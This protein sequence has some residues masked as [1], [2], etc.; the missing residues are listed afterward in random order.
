MIENV[1]SLGKVIKDGLATYLFQALTL[2]FA[3]AFTF[4]LFKNGELNWRNKQ[5]NIQ[6]EKRTQD[7]ILSE[8]QLATMSG[9]IQSQ[10]RYVERLE[11]QTIAMRKAG[12]KAVLDAVAN[13]KK[14]QA[15]I[16]HLRADNGRECNQ[17]GISQKIT[18]EIQPP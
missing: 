7:L 17:A 16:D 10:N 2:L 14:Q 5:T 3:L 12:D 18:Q 6:L 11:S 1:I 13:E 4:A 8:S 9:A 15:A